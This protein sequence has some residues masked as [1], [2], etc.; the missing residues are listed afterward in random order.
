MSN[1]MNK[2][3]QLV[4]ESLDS[5]NFS[6]YNFHKHNKPIKTQKGNLTRNSI[7]EDKSETKKYKDIK[8]QGVPLEATIKVKK[9]E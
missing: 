5:A 6:N 8:L 9:E 1:N 3:K 7:R 2:S 4:N